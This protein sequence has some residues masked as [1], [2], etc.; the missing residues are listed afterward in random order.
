MLWFCELTDRSR[1]TSTELSQASVN[2]LV[3]SYL[4]AWCVHLR[5]GLLG[6]LI[7]SVEFKHRR[8]RHTIQ[9]SPVSHPWLSHRMC[10][11]RVERQRGHESGR[12]VRRA[13]LSSRQP[14]ARTWAGGSCGDACG[15]ACGDV[16]PLSIFTATDRRD[17]LR[18][19]HGL[20]S[21]ARGK[22]FVLAV[23]W[24]RLMGEFSDAEAKQVE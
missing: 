11:V 21:R 15:D 10:M 6:A 13:F 7:S 1:Q 16:T 20:A 12:T 8:E 23:G 18:R 4:F 14:T 2:R 19:W 24:L 5:Q 9:T 17:M 22:T 3:P